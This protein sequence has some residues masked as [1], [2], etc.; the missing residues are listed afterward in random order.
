MKAFGAI[1]RTARTAWGE[2]IPMVRRAQMLTAQGEWLARRAT[3]YHVRV[4][5]VP[6]KIVFPHI[7][8]N[9]FPIPR[10]C[11]AVRFISAQR[12]ACELVKIDYR[13]VRES[14]VRCAYRE[15]TRANE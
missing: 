4:S 1:S 8:L 9:N 15:P 6:R 13:F 2:H 3:Y 7:A 10:G 11:H 14:R 12:G 5:F